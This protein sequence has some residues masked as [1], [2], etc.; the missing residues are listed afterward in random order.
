MP[1]GVLRLRKTLRVLCAGSRYGVG[2]VQ[3]HWDRE[4]QHDDNRSCWLRVA[5][6]WAGDRYGAVTL[7][8]VGMEV[9]LS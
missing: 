1:L 8:R 5:S 9:L 2:L 7:P 4:G 6:R 3:F